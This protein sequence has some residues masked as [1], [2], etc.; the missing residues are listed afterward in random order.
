MRCLQ[1]EMLLLEICCQHVLI[2]HGPAGSS[3]RVAT[4][5]VN[6]DFSGINSFLHSFWPTSP[7]LYATNL[8]NTYEPHK[9]VFNLSQK[10]SRWFL[11][12]AA[13]IWQSYQVWATHLFQK[14]F[15]PIILQRAVG[16]AVTFSSPVQLKVSDFQPIAAWCHRVRAWGPSHIR[17][18]RISLGSCERIKALWC[19]WGFLTVNLLVWKEQVGKTH[20]R[21][22]EI[23]E[24]IKI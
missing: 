21:W 14:N 22:Y 5:V 20:F 13:S 16:T 6:P 1:T 17:S 18:P 3:G 15:H 19:S 8:L 12:Y 4:A 2:L 9:A 11:E 23:H 10:P 7:C 24:S